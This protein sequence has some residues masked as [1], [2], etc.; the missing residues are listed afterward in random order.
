LAED[1][2]EG[3]LRYRS[4]D[5]PSLASGLRHWAAD[6]RLLRRARQAAWNAARSRWHW[7]DRREKGALLAAVEAALP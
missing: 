6:R 5:I 2:G 4:G 3:A 1:L 7:E